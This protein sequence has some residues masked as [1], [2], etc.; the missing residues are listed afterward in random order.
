MKVIRSTELIAVAFEKGMLDKYL[1][2]YPDSRKIL[3]QAV[4]WGA[5][6][7]G[8]AITRREIDT[9]VKLEV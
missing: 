4:L 5:K 3:L 6:L 9:V 2:P 1:P 8:A 7:N